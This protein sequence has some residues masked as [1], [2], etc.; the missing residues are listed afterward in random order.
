MSRTFSRIL[1]NHKIGGDVHDEYIIVPAMFEQLHAAPGETVG[2]YHRA[3]AFELGGATG[4]KNKRH[5]CSRSCVLAVQACMDPDE[6]PA[7]H[8]YGT[9]RLFVLGRGA[10]RQPEILL[11]RIQHQACGRVVWC[12]QN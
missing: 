7:F 4:S 8:G 6:P 11:G 12:H 10:A 3:R 1:M 9:V 5:Y 2:I